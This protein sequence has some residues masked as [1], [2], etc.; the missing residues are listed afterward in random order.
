[1]YR[2]QA[3]GLAQVLRKQSPQVVGGIYANLGAAFQAMG[4][5]SKAIQHFEKAKDIARAS[6][7]SVSLSRVLANLGNAYQVAFVFR[8]LY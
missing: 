6:D 1:M 2:G 8:L 3:V 7:D 5:C 4:D